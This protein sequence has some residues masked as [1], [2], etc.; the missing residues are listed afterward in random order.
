MDYCCP[1]FRH[2]D[3]EGYIEEDGTPQTKRWYARF[4]VFGDLEMDRIDYC[5]YCGSKLVGGESESE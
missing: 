3:N 2:S 5:P 1:E 4:Y